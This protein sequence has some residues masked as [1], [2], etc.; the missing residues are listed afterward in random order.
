[1]ATAC[2]IGALDGFSGGGGDAGTDD[3][4][5]PDGPAPVDASEEPAKDAS[6]DTGPALASGRSCA[7][8]KTVNLENDTIQTVRQ[9]GISLGD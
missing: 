7:A 8:I 3:G 1:M 6:A 4:G 2:S 5:L 9:L